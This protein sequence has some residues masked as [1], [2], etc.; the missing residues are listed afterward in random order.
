[1]SNT[2]L[3]SNAQ[4]M[5]IKLSGYAKLAAERFREECGE[6]RMLPGYIRLMYSGAKVITE[7]C[8]QIQAKDKQ[9]EKAVSVI[10]EAATCK[11][12]KHGDSKKCP[13]RGECGKEHSLWE[14][15]SE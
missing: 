3:E 5:A 6:E 9:L 11:T 4:S 7:L 10:R 12:C 1:M 8:N 15:D 13:I 2:T 14:F